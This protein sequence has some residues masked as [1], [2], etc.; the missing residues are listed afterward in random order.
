[1]SSATTVGY[2]LLWATHY[3]GLPTTMGRSP[4]MNEKKLTG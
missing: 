2:P 3:C 4:T 1:M